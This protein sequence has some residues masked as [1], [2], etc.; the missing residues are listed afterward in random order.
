MN[1]NANTNRDHLE[2][3]LEEQQQ[4]NDKPIKRVSQLEK[5]LLIL[6]SQL[7]I[8]ENISNFLKNKADGM[9]TYSHRSCVLIIV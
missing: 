4:Q 3:K 1:P 6:E 7:V 2:V 9:E 8:S 5:Q